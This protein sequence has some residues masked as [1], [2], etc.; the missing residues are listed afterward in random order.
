[1]IANVV[2]ERYSTRTS[3]GLRFLWLPGLLRITWRE[4]QR[5]EILGHDTDVPAPFNL[6]DICRQQLGASSAWRYWLLA[7]LLAGAGVL[8]LSLDS[9]AGIPFLTLAIILPY[10]LR[11]RAWQ[12][13]QRALKGLLRGVPVYGQLLAKY[14]QAVVVLPRE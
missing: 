11:L 12:R 3:G 13:Q 4:E 1:M 8:L 6:C 2:C 5:T 10:W 9:W 7:A 14:P